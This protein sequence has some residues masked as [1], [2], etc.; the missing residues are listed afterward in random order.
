MVTE[1]IPSSLEWIPIDKQVPPSGKVVQCLREWIPKGVN[2]DVGTRQQSL[3]AYRNSNEP[4]TISSDYGAN[5]WW[6]AAEYPTYSWSDSTVK[7]WAHLTLMP[8]P[9]K[10]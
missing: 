3:L 7:A 2:R 5:T 8:L 1:D 4:C 6:I 9:T 10:L